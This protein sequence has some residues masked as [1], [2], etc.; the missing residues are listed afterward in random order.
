ML[1]VIGHLHIVSTLIAVACALIIG[2]WVD[3]KGVLHKVAMPMMIFGTIVVTIGV[4]LVVPYQF[5]AHYIIY[6]GSTFVLLA[7]LLLLIYNWNNL[8]KER[9]AEQGIE[10]A[11][12]GE[13]FKALLHDPL[14]VWRYL[15]DVVHEFHHLLLW[16]SSLR[17]N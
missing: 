2:K 5:Y 3:F 6:G 1:A 7:G 10:N 12:F 16:A 11:T 8:I 15:A 14:K 4:W 17:S 13:K 9:I